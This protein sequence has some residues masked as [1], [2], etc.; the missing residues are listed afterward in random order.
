MEGSD[1]RNSSDRSRDKNAKVNERRWTNINR[2]ALQR[3]ISHRIDRL[4]QTRVASGKL[5]AEEAQELREVYSELLG[6]V[7]D[8][9]LTRSPDKF[10]HQLTQQEQDEVVQEVMDQVTPLATKRVLQRRS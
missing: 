10:D 6:G 8:D 4:S 7:I 3:S 5:T 2:G 1:E 9:V